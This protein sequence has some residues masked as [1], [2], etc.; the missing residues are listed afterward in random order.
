[1]NKYPYFYFTAFSC[2]SI[3]KPRFGI[4]LPSKCVSE[5][6]LVGERCILHC[7]PGYI[8]SHKR[9]LICDS[10]QTW[11]DGNDIDC[12]K[13][14]NPELFIKCPRDTTIMLRTDQKHVHVRLENPK[15]NM[16]SANIKSFPPW[17]QNGNVQLELGIHK[18]DFRAYTYDFK[19]YVTCSTVITVKAPEPPKI[20]FCPQSFEV[21]LD[22]NEIG[23]SVAWKEPI[24]ESN[25]TI[26]KIFK[27][28]VSI[29]TK[30]SMLVDK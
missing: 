15:S 26:K 21:D 4:I 27:S 18:I 29:W 20:I 8:P 2:A 7:L 16:N 10:N 14:N 22:A 11:S 13:I 3:S 30:S 17:A 25:A 6:S 23:K 9:V 12:V 5:R 19:K 24:F 1:M 28:K